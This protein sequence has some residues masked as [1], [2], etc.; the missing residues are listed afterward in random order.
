MNMFNNDFEKSYYKVYHNGEL[1][2]TTD[3]YTQ[4]KHLAKV[5]YETTKK[6]TA[7]SF[8][9]AAEETYDLFNKYIIE[10]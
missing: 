3:N 7:V 2:Y 9:E 4:A 8:Y 5:I 10:D 6:E 1:I